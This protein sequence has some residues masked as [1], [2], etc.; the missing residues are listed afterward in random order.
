MLKLT[1]LLAAGRKMARRK[2]TPKATCPKSTL[3]PRP[4]AFVRE[5]LAAGWRNAKQAAI[6]AGYA[7][8]PS[9]EVTASRLLRNPKVAAEIEKARGRHFRRYEITPDRVLRE[10]AN[11][12]YLDPA[13]FFDKRG[14]LLPVR[15]MPERARRAISTV[16]FRDG[17]PRWL[18]FR[19]KVAA[20]ETLIDYLGLLKR[21]PDAP[22]ARPVEEERLSVEEWRRLAEREG[23]EPPP[24]EG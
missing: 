16:R 6:C 3:R 18:I 11:I 15:R 5:Y 12:A 17:V 19:D 14:A 10:L 22:S 4:A 8:G 7:G 2:G 24:D 20:L 9:A 1:T 21:P 23:N 13:E